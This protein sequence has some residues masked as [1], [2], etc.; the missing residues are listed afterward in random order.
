MDEQ[1]QVTEAEALAELR[2]RFPL[3]V[4]LCITKV[5]LRKALAEREGDD[6]DRD[7]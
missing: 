5:A 7:A 1:I 4:E 2:A 3:E 6:A